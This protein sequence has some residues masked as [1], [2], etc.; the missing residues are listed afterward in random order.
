MR[1]W[2]VRHAEPDYRR[3]TITEVGKRQAQ[4]LAKV[5]A[6]ERIDR[7]FVSPFGRAQ[8]T[9]A[10]IVGHL[11][12]QMQTLSWLGELNGNW[13]GNRWAWD[14]DVSVVALFTAK[15]PELSDWHKVVP[16]G[17]LLLPQWR[18]LVQQFDAL[19]AEFGY[20]RAGTV[21]QVHRDSD[22]HLVFVT[23]AG[24]ILTLL[25]HLLNWALPLV[26][27]HVPCDVASITELCWHKRDGYAVPK[28]IRINDTAHWQKGD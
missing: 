2:L 19:L 11:G 25:S 8:A 28:L 18:H 3:D 13:T 7:L 21:Y 17:S 15:I 16:Y 24:V 1:I 23:H 22:A 27:V 6:R 5:L 20:I 10:E 12:V 9:A 26:Y 4:A 14:D